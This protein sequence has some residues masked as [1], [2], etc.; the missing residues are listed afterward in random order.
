MDRPFVKVL[1]PDGYDF[2]APVVRLIKVAAAGLRGNDLR[3]FIKRASHQFADAVRQVEFQPGDE[4]VH[5]I[6]LGATEDYGPNRNGDG[7]K[8]A[9]SRRYHDTF[10][11]YARWYH[12]HANKDPEKS[13]GLVKLSSFNEKMKRIELLVVL[14]STKAA[15]ARNGGL[16][17]TEEMEKLARGEDIPVSMA[18]KVPFD[19]CSGCGNKARNREEYCRGVD[20]GGLCKSGGLRHRI[21]TV[22]G[23][24]DNP[25]LHADNTD[26]L[27]FDISKVIRPAD[28][29]AYTLGRVKTASATVSGAALAE[30]LGVTAPVDLESTGTA[31]EMYKLARRLAA[32]EQTRDFADAWRFAFVDQP[33]TRWGDHGGKLGDA[34]QALARVKVAMPLEGFL[35]LVGRDPVKTASAASAARPYLS[36]IYTRLLETGE[37]HSLIEANPFV[38]AATLAPLSVRRWAEKKASAYS[39]ERATA[40]QRMLRGCLRHPALPAAMQYSVGTDSGPAAEIAKHYA[41]YKLAFLHA[42]R[43][44]QDLD[45]TMRLC[46]VQNYV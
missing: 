5:L 23:D 38:P 33:E 20:E 32:I 40:D 28:R 3:E 9:A 1:A 36:G 30:E 27:F 4:P 35:E 22:T 15:A 8:R 12:N 46:I 17:A 26:P 37:I 10:V 6:A 16:V 24:D 13:F 45:L 21:G 39:L 44:D 2:G 42:L 41:L 34:L 31:A 29:I 19:V 43:D 14:N 25:I 7:F 11:K 18:C